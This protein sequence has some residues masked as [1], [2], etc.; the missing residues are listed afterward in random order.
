MREVVP[1]L[2]RLAILANPTNAGAPR[3]WRTPPARS[4]NINL[5]VAEVSRVEDFPNA[6]A[7]IRNAHPD[8]LFMMSEPLIGGRI[9]Q[10]IEFAA[11]IRL[12]G[13]LRSRE[14]DPRRRADVVWTGFS[15]S[16][17]D[18]RRIRGQDS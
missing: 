16:L 8:G 9:A 6:F 11:G 15:R 5:V 7:V 17:R 14:C 12:P 10:V 2:A 13:I 4:Y 18:G 3:R 1:R